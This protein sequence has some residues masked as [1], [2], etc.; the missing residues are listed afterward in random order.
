MVSSFL[1]D[2]LYGTLD[3]RIRVNDKRG[4]NRMKNLK[5]N[6]LFQASK[7]ANFLRHWEPLRIS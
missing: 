4:I 3:P 6:Q 7:K 1:V 2:L 5:N